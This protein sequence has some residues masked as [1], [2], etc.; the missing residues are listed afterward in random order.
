ML[1][2]FLSHGQ[3]NC[4]SDGVVGLPLMGCSQPD[5]CLSDGT[6]M[7]VIRLFYPNQSLG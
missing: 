3:L 4:L 6:V 2:F 5:A 1:L 7:A